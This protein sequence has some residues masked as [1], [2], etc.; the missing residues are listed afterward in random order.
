MKNLELDTDHTTVDHYGAVV[1]GPTG[2]KAVLMSALDNCNRIACPSSDQTEN[3]C[4]TL[5]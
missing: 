2:I 1:D 4:N 5:L 3:G